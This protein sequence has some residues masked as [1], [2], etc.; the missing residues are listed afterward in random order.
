MIEVSIFGRKV[1]SVKLTSIKGSAGVEV[2]M[3]DLKA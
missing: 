2:S 3:D 1:F